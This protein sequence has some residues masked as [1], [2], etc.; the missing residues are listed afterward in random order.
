MNTNV[1]SRHGGILGWLLLL[2]C[3]L[4]LSEALLQKSVA[5]PVPD[6]SQVK[7]SRLRPGAFQ[8]N[9][10][11]LGGMEKRMGC[12]LLSFKNAIFSWLEEKITSQ[13]TEN[14]DNYIYLEPK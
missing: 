11:T 8:E 3:Q 9:L 13:Q 4:G 14:Y 10:K 5:P 12:K 2:L 6:S 1:L 7:R